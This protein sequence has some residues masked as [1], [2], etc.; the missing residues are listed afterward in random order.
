MGRVTR[1]E[2]ADTDLDEFW[3]PIALDNP[4]AADRFLERIGER[5]RLLAEHP[6][7]GPARPNIAQ[8]ARTIVVGDYLA[9]YSV[10]GVD[11]E[12]VRVVHGARRLEGLFDTEA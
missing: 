3:L 7:P 6:K 4:S 2:R 5:C 12:I 11:V 10:D 9:P 1:T 8:N